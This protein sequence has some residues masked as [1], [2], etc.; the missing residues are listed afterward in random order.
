MARETYGKSYTVKIVEVESGFV[1]QS[2]AKKHN[3][4]SAHKILYKFVQ[5]TIYIATGGVLGAS[6]KNS[7]KFMKTYAGYGDRLV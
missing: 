1:F 3:G 4:V 5:N 6:H 2:A 7:R